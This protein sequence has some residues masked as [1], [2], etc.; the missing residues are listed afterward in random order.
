MGYCGG[1]EWVW[2]RAATADGILLGMYNTSPL[3]FRA[4]GGAGEGTGVVALS[5]L[6]CYSLD[7]TGAFKSL[8]TFLYSLA[9]HSQCSVSRSRKR[10]ISCQHQRRTAPASI[11]SQ[12]SSPP[13]L[14]HLPRIITSCRGILPSR[15]ES[16]NTRN[17]YTQCMFCFIGA[18]ILNRQS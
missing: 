5:H 13:R 6:P 14:V 10:H 15:Q 8:P 11:L 3:W 18:G 2:F 12:H 7:H 4:G 16:K 17:L 1:E 9:H